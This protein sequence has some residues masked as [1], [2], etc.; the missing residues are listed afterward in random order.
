MS[1]ELLGS[2]AGIVL[3]LAFSYIPGL[4][5]LFD[6]LLPTQK[7]AVMGGLLLAVALA[8]FG[9]SCGGVVSAVTCD[10]PGALGLLSTLIAALVAN[11]AVY[12][13]TRRA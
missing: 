1:V 10:K 3:T 5:D 2:I 11:Q 8:V 13:L 9:L 4:S 12:K 7:Q 6:K